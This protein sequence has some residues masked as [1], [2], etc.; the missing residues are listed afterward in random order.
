VLRQI[1][2]L[3]SSSIKGVF[4]EDKGIILS[5]NSRQVEDEK[6]NE[7]ERL[8]KKVIKQ[9]VSRGLFNITSTR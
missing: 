7:V 5:V 2:V 3:T 4:V 8:V 9:P 1:L 6:A